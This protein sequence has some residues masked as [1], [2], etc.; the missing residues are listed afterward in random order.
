M[1]R[2]AATDRAD[3][4]FAGQDNLQRRQR[5]ATDTSSDRDRLACGI[6]QLLDFE[7]QDED[8]AFE[9]VRYRQGKGEAV[10]RLGEPA[11]ERDRAGLVAF[12]AQQDAVGPA[13][14]K[15]AG[16]AAGGTHRRSPLPGQAPGTGVLGMDAKEAGQ[17][18][19]GNAGKIGQA[20][21]YLTVPQCRW[22]G[23]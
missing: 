11:G 5:V 18:L 17:G 14:R 12:T 10:Y 1:C 13:C 22:P 4:A 15:V 2:L 16:N 19:G 9:Q 3:D 21:C 7:Q 23:P 6:G 20:A 8:I